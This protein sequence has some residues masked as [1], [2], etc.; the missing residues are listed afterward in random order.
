M[1]EFYLPSHGKGQLHCV[2]WEPEG[3]IRAVVQIV[4]GIAEYAARY[5]DFARYLNRQGILVVAE[6][7][8]G[9]GGTLASGDPLGYFTGGW[10]A[11]VD[12]TFALL[13]KTQED[14]PA[15]PYCILGHSMGSFMTRTLLYRH[16]SCRLDAAVICG[17]AWQPAPL[18]KAGL[19]MCRSVCRS[20]GETR[21]SPALRNL[22]FGSYNKR[23]SNPRTPFDWV[24]GE[25]QV[26]DA[27]VAD[28]LCGFAETA[29]LDRDMLAGIQMNQK[30][31]NLA[32]MPKELPVLFVAGGQDP[33]G[34]YGKGVRKSAEAFRRA[35]LIDVTTILYPN[36]RHEI[37][38]DVEKS[39]V[40]L[41]ISQWIDKK[42]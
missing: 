33:V 22:I 21:P 41:D 27:Y 12:D 16:A 38:N 15:V 10:T 37:L 29:G 25:P 18:L 2:Q 4:H 28:P 7:H 1:T 17:T 13:E 36:S 35:G 34:N 31:E 19:A 40:Y 26:I 23:I 3:K 20:A 5:G 24:C 42:L 6:D 11:A 32:K 39:Q 30:P 9:H 14:Y 8:M